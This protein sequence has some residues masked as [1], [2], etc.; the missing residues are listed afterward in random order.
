V[1]ATALSLVV[2]AVPSLAMGAGSSLGVVTLTSDARNS[3]MTA[4]DVRLNYYGAQGSEPLPAGLS[5]SFG[6]PKTARA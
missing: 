3:A 4:L 1:A 6:A 5:V 2:N